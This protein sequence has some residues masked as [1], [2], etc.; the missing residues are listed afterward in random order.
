MI[1]IIFLIV[2][3]YLFS[4]NSDIITVRVDDWTLVESGSSGTAMSP[5]PFTATPN[6]ILN[7]SPSIVAGY[8]VAI[9]NYA[10]IGSIVGSGRTTLFKIANNR[11]PNPGITVNVVAGSGVSF[12]PS[13]APPGNQVAP[14][15]TATYMWVTSTTIQ[16]IE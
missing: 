8:T 3:V 14:G 2:V 13:V 1:A 9:N 10:S 6:T 16:R 11:T 15:T 7:V 5:E 4:V 12:A